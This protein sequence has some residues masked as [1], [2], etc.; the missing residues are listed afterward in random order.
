MVQSWK[1]KRGFGDLVTYHG[2]IPI[3]GTSL[4]G[5]SEVSWF[6]H[7]DFIGERLKLGRDR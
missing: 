3:E 7:C 2:I 5:T 4:N 1:E 6:S